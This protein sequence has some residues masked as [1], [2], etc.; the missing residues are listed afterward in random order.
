MLLESEILKVYR[1]QENIRVMLVQ[2]KKGLGRTYPH[3]V[4]CGKWVEEK[5]RVSTGISPRKVEI[6]G[7]REALVFFNEQVAIREVCQALEKCQPGIQA[8]E[9]SMPNRNILIAEGEREK[10]IQEINEKFAKSKDQLQW[11]T[12]RVQEQLQA[13]KMESV[14]KREFSEQEV[15]DFRKVSQPP[16]FVP[17]SGTIPIPRGECGIEAF[18]YQ[19]KGALVS[20]TERAVRLA[21]SIALQGGARE[22]VEYKGLET[23]LHEMMEELEMR[24]GGKVSQDELI[25]Q[26]HELKQG[27]QE[28]R[29]FTSRIE[30]VWKLVQQQFPGKY[31]EET[32]L[33]GRLFQGM[34]RS[35]R[36]SL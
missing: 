15:T 20:R 12:Q 6:R 17:F 10:E 2:L 24:Y 31:N 19:I 22:F 36:D 29:D 16:K 8:E 18:L 11:L 21:V 28:N 33:K 3:K 30:R 32:T 13:M 34:Q 1:D 23:P 25:C 14:Q 26:F 35:L 5:C 4:F 7:P 27:E 9:R